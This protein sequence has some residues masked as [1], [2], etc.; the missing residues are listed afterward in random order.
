MSIK[1]NRGRFFIVSCFIVNIGMFFVWGGLL[2]VLTKEA[3]SFWLLFIAL[4]M[5]QAALTLY[6]LLAYP[7]IMK[8]MPQL[9]QQDIAA[10]NVQILGKHPIAK[11]FACTLISLF[12]RSTDQYSY[13]L[14]SKQAEM[15]AM[16]SQIQPHFL[17]NALDSIRGLALDEGA[18]RTADMAESL[19]VLYRSSIDKSSDLLTLDQELRGID[20]YIKIQQYRFGNRFQVQKHISPEVQNMLFR[21][22]LPKLTLQ[23]IIE[24]AIYHGIDAKSRDGEITISIY[25]TQSRLLIDIADNGQGMDDH[26]LLTL[27]Q[28][29]VENKLVRQSAFSTDT[30]G[31]VALI[32]VNARL[33]FL[34]GDDYGLS[35]YSTLGVG[36]IVQIVLPL[37]V[38][39][40]E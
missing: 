40:H 16:Q 12:A 17:Y 37:L 24:N 8:R 20:N 10:G 3:L 31:G 34:F 36:T 7:Q 11:A 19:S 30:K 1:K 5:L 22:R 35:I 15:N 26:T 27:N 32:N 33:R 29:F 21:Y 28:S 14:L 13:E 18:Y 9:S 2:A 39:S 23:P 38:D 25:A 4:G 6:C